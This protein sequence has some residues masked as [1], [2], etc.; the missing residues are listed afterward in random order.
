MT[1]LGEINSKVKINTGELLLES[2]DQSILLVLLIASSL[3]DEV[4]AFGKSIL[5]KLVEGLGFDTSTV[6]TTTIGGSRHERNRK[7]AS[8]K[9]S[10]ETHCESRKR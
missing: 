7:E 5:V 10:L 8:G 1:Y 9:E 6:I 4:S 3:H 2:L